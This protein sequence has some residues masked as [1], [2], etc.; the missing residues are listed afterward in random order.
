MSKLAHEINAQLTGAVKL[1]KMKYVEVDHLLE[2][3]KMTPTMVASKGVRMAA[4]FAHTAWINEFGQ[5]SEG[6]LLGE[7]M[8]DT[9]RAIIEDV[10]GEFRPMLIEMRCAL[11]DLDTDRLRRILTEMEHQMFVDGM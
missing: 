1:K 4:T 10:F 7:A 9:K 6:T 2:P 5:A 8:Y 3:A 11:H